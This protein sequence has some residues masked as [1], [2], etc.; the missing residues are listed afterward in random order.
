MPSGT[1]VDRVANQALPEV[2]FVLDAGCTCRSGSA[3]VHCGLPA[4]V[5]GR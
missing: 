1:A 5:A 2:T 3:Q 4:G